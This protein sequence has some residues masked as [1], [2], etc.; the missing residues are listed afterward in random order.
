MALDGTGSVAS[1]S[2]DDIATVLGP[3]E[4]IV[5]QL[6]ATASMENGAACKT[7][8]G[9]HM[10]VVTKCDED[11][12]HRLLVVV[13]GVKDRRV[14]AQDNLA[15]AKHANGTFTTSAADIGFTYATQ[16]V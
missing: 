10:L 12:R 5:L 1:I 6:R 16:Q 4:H 7:M 2:E 14:T 9:Q 11:S 3:T 8:K 15:G 13:V